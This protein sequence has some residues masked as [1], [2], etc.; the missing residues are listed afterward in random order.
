MSQTLRDLAPAV[1]A[2]VNPVLGKL[3]EPVLDRLREYDVRIKH[4]LESQTDA[5]ET[6][7]GR[8]VQGG[9]TDQQNMTMELF[10]HDPASL[11]V[12]LTHEAGHVATGLLAERVA[13]G[14]SDLRA[15]W[16]GF[17]Q[18]TREEFGVSDYA[19]YYLMNTGAVWAVT[20][21]HVGGEQVWWPIAVQEN[22]AELFGAAIRGGPDFEHITRTAPR[23]YAAFRPLLA[24]LRLPAPSPAH[25]EMRLGELPAEMP[26]PASLPQRAA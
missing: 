21:W 6:F 18:A 4:T 26:Y 8:I 20:V 14:S 13:T 12:T 2:A 15:A 22:F 11:E 19:R 16:D 7:G 24:A 5:P 17:M 3:P 1:L 23:T 10:D 9:R 25:V